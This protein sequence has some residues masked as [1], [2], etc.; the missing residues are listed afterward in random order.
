MIGGR[1][2]AAVLAGFVLLC[3]KPAYAQ[4]VP[5][6]EAAKAL[7]GVLSVINRAESW[8]GEDKGQ[9]LD[10]SLRWKYAGT[11]GRD[12]LR[13]VC[14]NF[15]YYAANGDPS[16]NRVA[17]LS[18]DLELEMEDQLITGA[19][20]VKGI[21]QVSSLRFAK[22]NNNGSGSLEINGS[23][24]D[25]DAVEDILDE[26]A[27]LIEDQV[28]VTPEIEAVVV[29]LTMFSAIEDAGM[30]EAMPEDVD[31]SRGIPPGITGSNPQGTAKFVTRKNAFEI[32]FNA[33][34]YGEP[35][36]K[37][38]SPLLDGKLVMEYSFDPDT[39]TV[40]S[41]VWDSRLQIT[42]ISLISSMGFDSC[43]IRDLISGD[44]MSGA[45]IING[46]SYDFRDFIQVLPGLGVF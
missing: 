6:Q 34:Q 22:F 18:G 16:K 4:T 17:A 25:N 2:G 8:Y 11:E 24:Y 39:D 7:A 1:T 37:N 42:N 5:D 30:A 19:V 3:S 13:V 36:F 12:V 33:Y 45:I 26:A 21:P 9:N 14:S 10:G 27:G 41:V 40:S 32:S 20:N 31:G 28:I 23:R 29:F 35:F 46:V 43:M 38:V 15:R 44:D